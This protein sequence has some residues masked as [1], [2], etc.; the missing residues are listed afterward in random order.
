MVL[1]SLSCEKIDM[2][3]LFNADWG[4]SKGGFCDTEEAVYRML[5]SA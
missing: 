1:R 2:G 3:R 5:S 4:L